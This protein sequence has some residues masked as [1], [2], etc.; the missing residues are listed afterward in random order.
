MF[1]ET[2]ANVSADNI[3][4]VKP[5]EESSDMKVESDSSQ[6]SSKI[7]SKEQEYKID[8]ILEVTKS[9]PG[10]RDEVPITESDK[11]LEECMKTI[12]SNVESISTEKEEKSKDM[13]EISEFHTKDNISESLQI[14]DSETK[15]ISQIETQITSETAEKECS[16]S[17]VLQNQEQQSS[18]KESTEKIDTIGDKTSELATISLTEHLVSSDKAEQAQKDKSSKETKTKSESIEEMANINTDSKQQTDSLKESQTFAKSSSEDRTQKDLNMDES[19]GETIPSESSHDLKSLNVSESIP[20]GEKTTIIET[21]AENK[22]NVKEKQSEDMNVSQI[23]PKLSENSK[24]I[25]KE[26]NELATIS[27]TEHLVS[28]DKAEQAQKDKSP[29]ET[30]TKSESIEEMANMNTDSKQ[31]TDSLKESLFSAKSSSEDISQKDSN[32]DQTKDK[33]QNVV[34]TGFESKTIVH[35]LPSTHVRRTSQVVEQPLYEDSD[36]EDN[37]ANQITEQMIVSS[38]L[39]ADFPELISISGGTTPSQSAPQSPHDSKSLSRSESMRSREKITIIDTIPEDKDSEKANQSVDLNVSQ[40][41][42]KLSENSKTIHEITDEKQNKGSNISKSEKLVSD[43][44]SVQKELK[45]TQSS[46]KSVAEVYESKPLQTKTTFMDKEVV[47]IESTSND[48][49]K[50]N[51][52]QWGKPLSLP[53]PPDPSEKLLN[54]TNTMKSNSSNAQKMSKNLKKSNDAESCGN[55]VYVE[56]AY[57]PHHADQHY[58]NADYFK[59]VRAKYYVFSG[60]NPHREVFEALIEGKKIWDKQFITTVI[61]TH[62]SEALGFWINNNRDMLEEFKICVAPAADR[63]SVNLQDHET[64]CSAYRVEF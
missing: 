17:S 13:T 6:I 26:A 64:K 22:D 2:K 9:K 23:D 42:P 12:K 37:R 53:T 55:A 33:S 15:N 7:V 38:T 21:I 36:E 44:S 58:C 52:D 29:K 16:K 43:S 62:E 50:F 57:V 1:S 5:L 18:R 32:L 45:S 47:I 61:P 28:S 41:D 20:S 27:L 10:N 30:K 59:R 25:S 3:N 63:C 34:N 39:S 31:Q 49:Q 19:K 51:S 46:D 54:K 8:S 60:I 11:K 40:I 56:L 24:T 4:L 14:K 48:N 35:S